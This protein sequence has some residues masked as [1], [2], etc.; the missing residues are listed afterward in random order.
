M[1]GQRAPSSRGLGTRHERRYATVEA[2]FRGE[3]RGPQSV[4]PKRMS[5]PPELRI[6]GL[7]LALATLACG[8][9]AESRRDEAAPTQPPTESEGG[10]NTPPGDGSPAPG[11]GSPLG[12]VI[13][14]VI[15]PS[16]DLDTPGAQGLCPVGDL[17]GNDTVTAEML[18][19]GVRHEDFA[20]RTLYSWTTAEQVRELREEPTLLTRAATAEGE[21]G[22]ASEVILSHA[23]SDPLAALLAAPRFANKRF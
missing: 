11:N 18:A 19:F 20:R 23:S 14:P 13:A 9:A 7:S 1:R 21:P 5:P 16:I 17:A 2:R 15:G 6:T 4:H 8:G 3:A 10:T 22:R 12:P